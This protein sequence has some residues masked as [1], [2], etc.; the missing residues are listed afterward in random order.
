MSSWLPLLRRIQ[1]H[2]KLLVLMCEPW[3]V[4]TLVTELE[5]EGLL[6]TTYCESEEEARELLRKVPGWMKQRHWVIGGEW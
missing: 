6:M 1:A 5:P 2:G 4:E 3:E